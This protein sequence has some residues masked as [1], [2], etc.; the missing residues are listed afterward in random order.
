MCFIL[1]EHDRRPLRL[2]G[3]RIVPA[4][5]CAINLEELIRGEYIGTTTLLIVE[6]KSLGFLADAVPE[7]KEAFALSKPIGVSLSEN[8]VS[9][10][11]GEVFI[12]SGSGCFIERSYGEVQPHWPASLRGHWIPVTFSPSGEQES[13]G[14]IRAWETKIEAVA[15]DGAL[16]SSGKVVIRAVY[17]SSLEWVGSEFQLKS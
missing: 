16:V 5:V 9:A 3:A 2:R 6:V 10:Q 15:V 8:A 4:V 1:L 7:A 11:D 12:P 13:R 14:W 17:D